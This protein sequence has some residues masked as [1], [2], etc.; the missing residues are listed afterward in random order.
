MRNCFS[1]VG[2]RTHGRTFFHRGENFEALLGENG[3]DG[4]NLLMKILNGD[5]MKDARGDHRK[6]G[7]V[8]LKSPRD[9]EHALASR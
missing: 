2:K 9:A 1:G 6:M 4:V 5:Y 3:N 8:E 7:A